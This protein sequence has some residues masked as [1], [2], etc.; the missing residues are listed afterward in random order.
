M[1]GNNASVGISQN[2]VYKAEL[3][4]RCDDLIYLL[5]G[6][7]ARVARIRS[8]RVYRA[9]GDRKRPRPRRI[10]GSSQVGISRRSEQVQHRL[11]R[12]GRA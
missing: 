12:C 11:C 10:R 9:I 5:L 3:S 2:R 1:A 4:D 7:R 6:M 8:K